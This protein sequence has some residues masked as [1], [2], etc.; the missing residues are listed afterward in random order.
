MQ[1]S[2]PAGLPTKPLRNHAGPAIHPQV[3]FQETL[4]GRNTKY[5]YVYFKKSSR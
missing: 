1:T 4:R 5:D 2:V 3:P